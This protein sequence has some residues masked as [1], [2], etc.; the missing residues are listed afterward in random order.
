MTDEERNLMV[1]LWEEKIFPLDQNNRFLFLLTKHTCVNIQGW[2][3]T[4]CLDYLEGKGYRS[5]KIVSNPDYYA[6]RI[7][8]TAGEFKGK[9]RL[10]ALLRAVKEAG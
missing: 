1:E 4:D 2:T 5:V 6:V 7:Y 8:T 9:T 3:E 10:E